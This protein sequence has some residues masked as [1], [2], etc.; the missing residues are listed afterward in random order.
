M[1][2]G[3]L[4]R[5]QR[6]ATPNGVCFEPLEP[7]L[8]LSGSWGAGV[9]APSHDSQRAPTAASPRRPWWSPRTS[10]APE[11][12]PSTKPK[13]CQTAVQVDALSQAPVLSAVNAVD[14]VLEAPSTADL[15]ASATV[16]NTANETGSDSDMQPDMIVAAGIY[17]LVFVNENIADYQQLI[18]DLQGE[19]DNRII[20]VVVLDADRD[21]IEQVSDILAE[22]SDLAAVHFVTHGDEGQ[23]NL[24]STWLNSADAAAKQRR[25]DRLGRCP[26]R[27]GGYSLLRLQHRRRQRGQSLLN[28]IADLTGAD[29]A[30]SD[31]LTGNAK[32]G[33]D[34]E[35]EYEN[36]EIETNVAFSP[37]TRQ[38]LVRRAG[39]F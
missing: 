6:C 31:D 5:K 35:L 32:L 18:A 37:E 3:Q 17:E 10:S 23:I 24:G 2:K 36:G 11:R 25:G 20:E 28:T 7:R 33:G 4:I 30:A 19:N 9:D 29:V 15:V 34:W 1:K 26:E 16:N 27:N 22:R 39:H 12:I 13:P 38:T 21:G 14:R 8:L